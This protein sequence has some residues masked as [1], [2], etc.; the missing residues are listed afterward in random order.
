[1]IK[2]NTGK[3][4]RIFVEETIGT[5]K[6]FSYRADLI[7]YKVL[8][9]I[10][11]YI[12]IY[13]ITSELFISII[14]SLQVLLI[15]TL[16][17][18]LNIDKKNKEG[19]E[20]LLN[21]VKRDFFKKKLISMDTIS[22]ERLIGFYFNKQEYSNYKKIGRY[23]FSATK[24]GV[25]S[26]IRIFKMFD[27]A[28]LEKIDIRNF[29]SFICNNNAASGY[30][31][32][33]N[34]INEETMKLIENVNDDLTIKIINIDMLF[35]FAK[36]NNLLPENQY[37]YNQIY[38]ESIKVKNTKIKAIKNNPIDSKKIIIYIIAAIFFYII[39]KV[40]PYNSLSIY[41]CL[42]FIILTIVNAAYIFINKAGRKIIKPE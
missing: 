37:F 18:K 31:V 28:D 36:K 24:S 25:I 6:Y 9:S 33:I 39:S 26:F 11:I 7:L 21:K 15:L 8:F 34:T 2:E 12:L 23:T 27:K 10:F 5:G 19:R 4:E 17:N 16:V 14:M 42:Y 1:M 35:D 41:I 13:M 20:R 32:T 40:M 22:F 38:E 3:S 29:I 30:I